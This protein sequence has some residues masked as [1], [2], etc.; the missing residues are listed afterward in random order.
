MEPTGGWT[1]FQEH[2]IG[3]KYSIMATLLLVPLFLRETRSEALSLLL[4]A[5]LTGPPSSQLIWGSSVP[6]S[7]ASLHVIVIAL[8]VELTRASHP[9]GTPC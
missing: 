5:A 6:A 4:G 3:W 2:F 8:G 1:L 7:Q 9:F